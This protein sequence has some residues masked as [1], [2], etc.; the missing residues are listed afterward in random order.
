MAELRRREARRDPVHVLAD[1]RD[2]ARQG[3]AFRQDFLDLPR[4]GEACSAPTPCK[5]AVAGCNG[6]LNRF[7][8]VSGAALSC[9]SGGV[10][11]LR[12]S[13]VHDRHRV[14]TAVCNLADPASILCTI[15]HELLRR[16]ARERPTLMSMDKK[17]ALF[18]E[19]DAITALEFATTLE[20]EDRVASKAFS[21][22][23]PA[24][25]T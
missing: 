24:A 18:R 2:F 3:A 25:A 10:S 21:W 4:P 5:P 8:D 17:V 16:S 6:W 11:T 19:D 7:Q 12:W 20:E 23:H 1:V 15:S 22:R 13:V 14:K 9:K